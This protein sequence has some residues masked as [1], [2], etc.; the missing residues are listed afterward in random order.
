MEQRRLRRAVAGRVLGWTR[1]RLLLDTHAFIWWAIRKERL[2]PTAIRLCEDANNDV[3]LS[4]VSLWEMQLKTQLGKLQL[5]L[6]LNEL[7][8]AQQ[9]I[10]GLQL[11]PIEPQHIYAL[12]QL[13]FHHKDPFDRLLVSQA[14][15]EKL[16]LISGDQTL[17]AYAAQIL[18]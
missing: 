13:P 9:R 17:S 18:W 2:S 16:P 10:N 5:K 12:S 7:I 1:M 4:I 3:L 14:I 6:P 11:L 15:T 8:E